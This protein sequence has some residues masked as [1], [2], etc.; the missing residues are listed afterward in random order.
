MRI[1]DILIVLIYS[2]IATYGYIFPFTTIQS[3]FHSHLKGSKA[4]SLDEDNKLGYQT[5]AFKSGFVSILGNP[6]VGKSSLLNSLLGQKLSIV[7]YKPQT[8]RH[9]IQGIISTNDYQLVFSDTPG[10][11]IVYAINY[12][13]IMMSILLSLCRNA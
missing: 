7:S 9:R 8:T 11:N 5:H 3:R 1:S 12:R 6:N 10:T 13:A 4:K 2:F